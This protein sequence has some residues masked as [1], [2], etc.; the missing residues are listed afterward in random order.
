MTKIEDYQN[1]L[2]NYESELATIIDANFTDEILENK[3]SDLIRR[4]VDDIND[5]AAWALSGEGA[6]VQAAVENAEVDGTDP[7]LA[8]ITAKTELKD[9][10]NG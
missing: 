4:V 7:Y 6:G 10:E 8:G 9:N 3:I 1:R 5:F 2:T